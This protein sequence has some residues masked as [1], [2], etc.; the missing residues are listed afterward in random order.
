TR[1]KF[2]KESLSG[3][4][5]K[6]EVED[7]NGVKWKIKMGTEARPETAATRLLWAVG[8]YVDEDYYLPEIVVDGMLQLS[9]GRHF[10]R[11]GNTVMDV[12]LERHRKGPDA[13]DWKWSD[14]PFQGTQEFN[15][16]RVLMGL[17]NNWDLKDINNAI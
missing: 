13:M 9:R 1:F 2:L 8:Y 17:I 12:R 11:N 4:A 7:E 10:V 14:N 15:G 16:L 5:P 6:I 3:S